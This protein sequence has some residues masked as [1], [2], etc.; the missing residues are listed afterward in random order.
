M[1]CV[2]CNAPVVETTGDE[3]VCIACGE[4]PIASV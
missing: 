2:E 1:K 4:S 3:Y